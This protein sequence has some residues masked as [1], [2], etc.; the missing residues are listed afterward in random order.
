MS[1]LQISGGIYLLCLTFMTPKYCLIFMAPNALPY[2]YGSQYPALYSWLPNDL[3]HIHGSQMLCFILMIP[4]YSVIFVA[5]C[6]WLTDFMNCPIFQT[7]NSSILQLQNKSCYIH[8]SQMV[9]LL[10]MASKLTASY[11][12]LPNPLPYIHGSQMLCHIHI[13][14][15]LPII[16]GPKMFGH[17]HGYPMVCLMVMVSYIHSS[18]I[19]KYLLL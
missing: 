12:W 15:A 3:S 10:F 16:Y 17:I 8:G 13:L 5:Q 4:K 19:H 14:N 6:S 9:C 2:N 11:S 18:Q 7:P 1:T